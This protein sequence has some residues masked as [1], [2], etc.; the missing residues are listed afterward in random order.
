MNDPLFIFMAQKLTVSNGGTA[1]TSLPQSQ[2]VSY[3]PAASARLPTPT[4]VPCECL[5]LL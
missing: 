3:V 5:K 2:S 4:V 1:V